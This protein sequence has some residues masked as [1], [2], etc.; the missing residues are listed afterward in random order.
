MKN[1]NSIIREQTKK[2]IEKIEKEKKKE[3]ELEYIF[4]KKKKMGLEEYIKVLE[5]MKKRS[6]KEKIKY[7]TETTLDVTY[8]KDKEESYRITIE[9]IEEINK[10]M[11]VL[12]NRKSHIIYNILM[13]M[14]EKE[15][16]IKMI[17]KKKKRVYD[18]EELDMRVRLSE[19]KEI[20]KEKE[21][22]EDKR[23]DI[24]F[25][26]KQRVTIEP[27]GVKIEL[28]NVKQNREIN[29]I[30]NT[31]ARYELE[32]EKRGEGEMKR[33]KEEV[34]KML[35]VI[36]ESKEVI[37]KDEQE[38]VLRKYRELLKVS[39]KMIN[40]DGRKAQSLEVQH[41][42]EKLP[43]RYAVTDKAD[44]ER[45]FMIIVKKR[46]YLISYNLEVKYTGIKIEKE[47]YNNSILDGEYI[48]IKEGGEIFMAFDCLRKGKE[49]IRKEEKFMERIKKADE[50]I[51]ECFIR[52]E[53]E[54]YKH[55]EYK[56]E[57]K[58]EKIKEYHEKE[59][60]KYMRSIRKDIEEE[61]K[62]EKK[63][64][65][66]RK[67]FIPVI[68][69]RDNEIYKYSEMMWEKY[70]YDKEVECPYILDGLVYHP[71]EQRYT[72]RKKEIERYEYKWKPENKNSIDFYIR[73]E[74]DRKTGKILTLY[75]NTKGEMKNKPYRII[76]L[77]VGEMVKGEEIPVLFDT[78]EEAEYTA[79]V[80]IEKGGVR[81][82]E[83][84]II[85]DETVV[86]FYYEKEREK[87][88]RW[89]P[90]RTRHDKTESVRRYKRKY[91]NYKEI[92]RRIWRS[93][94]NPFTMKDIEILG[95]DKLYERQI[96]K[97]KKS[98]D[99]KVII[100]EN[101]EN[102][103][104]QKITNIAKPMKAFHNWIKSILIYTH[105]NPTYEKEKQL[106][107]LDIACGRGGDIMKFYYSK[108]KYYVGI[109]IDNNGIISPT[110][111]A[112]S[113]YNKL[114]KTHPRFPN[115]YFIHADAGALLNYEEQ[116]KA[117]GTMTEA[118]KRLIE[119]FFKEEKKET[120]K[121]DRINCQFAIHYFLGNEKMW[122]NFTENINNTL[123]AGGY[124]LITCFDGD[125]VVDEIK[126][127][128]KIEATY[129][130]EKGEKKILFEIKRQYEEKEN[131]NNIG[132]GID[133]YNSLISQ[134][135]VY[136]REYIVTKE[137]LTRELKEK[138]DMEIIE[139][140]LF[141]N[142]YKIHEEYFKKIVKYEENEKTKRFLE[143]VAEYYKENEINKAS[144][145]KT[146][147]NRY[148]VF[149]KND[150]SNTKVIKGGGEIKIKEEK[151]KEY[152]D[153]LNPE[154][155]I[156]REIKGIKKNTYLASV[157]NILQESKI[158]PSKVGI[159]EFYKDLEID[160]YN[161][162]ELDNKKIKKIN[163]KMKIYH[164]IENGSE[165]DNTYRNKLVMDG[166]NVITLEKDCDGITTVENIGRK[167]INKKTPT[168]ILSK[169]NNKYK[170]I[171]K[172]MQ[173]NKTIGLYDSRIKLIKRLREI[174][175]E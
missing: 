125:R 95:K 36:Q 165:S 32:I 86:E 118:N 42:I 135:G 50:I 106:T 97:L 129:T 20:K 91:G 104:Y 117:L 25:R 8:T 43:N 88:Y 128:K 53:H 99:S 157:H 121:F 66:R 93:I 80:Y 160:M 151:V 11:R 150:I 109:D 64:I 18:M 175:D 152:E 61:K 132:N 131:Y 39:E 166:I 119:R 147:L 143:N 72:T 54:G 74:R 105:C 90:M 52:K 111:G 24:I 92:A 94:K 67:Y 161:D 2:E 27:E 134:E 126:K 76:K 120:V 112:I 9:G 146:K 174:S 144:L 156:E 45:Y 19:E 107:V 48:K 171:L 138:C 145:K 41:V 22:G 29:R 58:I 21:I 68:G 46:V 115:M 169:K 137:F 153:I 82:I 148:Y 16:K 110:D 26:Y 13:K 85:Q 98:I 87:E 155:Y 59:I 114:K 141:E 130:N 124:M 158:I 173:E 33:I 6:E 142:Q 49:D 75:D 28:T 17:R 79:N 100:S 5:Y 4:Y 62:K 15:D 60:K 149:R 44:G 38:E 84:R 51:E 172:K 139:T 83:G 34:Y 57:K 10:I 47:D 159:M 103:Y 113:R 168:I 30:E 12:H 31:N 3:D 89:I 140:D 78:G 164:E 102:I 81:D 127:N 154:K 23:R 14:V 35:E 7:K 55:R 73:Y 122:E 170:P 70:V 123:K 77:Y 56:G 108:V 71:L 116:K 37:N 63:I 162:D 69:L 136:N 65:I 167:K 40:L 163:K 101:K 133:V 96:N 1:I